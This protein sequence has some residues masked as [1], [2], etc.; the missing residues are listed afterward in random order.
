MAFARA[1]L[2]LVARPETDRD[3]LG[4][5][6]AD[7]ARSFT[8]K[9]DGQIALRIAVPVAGADRTPAA[10]GQANGAAARFDAVI[11]SGSPSATAAWLS[12]A[13][14]EV[15]SGVCALID[16]A[17]SGALSGAVTVIMP[18]EGPYLTLY[19]L[20]RILSMS[21]GEFHDY[22]LNRHGSL[23]RTVPGLS[24]YRQFHGDP[25]QT[26]E[27]ARGLGFGVSD[28]DGCAEGRRATIQ[29]AAINR[30]PELEAVLADEKN[31][32]D[33]ARCGPTMYRAIFGSRD[34]GG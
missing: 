3:A 11:S 26:A 28:F 22:W 12:A 24:G 33:L 25:R 4:Q 6:L 8:S 17:S 30:G 18:G 15:A 31:F 9:A 29:A 5:L 27:L 21:A 20:R 7:G 13:V 10:S 16:R 2:L 32:I 1:D 19:P 34:F 14:A 23:A